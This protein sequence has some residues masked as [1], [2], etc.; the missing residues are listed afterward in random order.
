MPKIEYSAESSAPPERVLAAATDFTERR[1]EIWPNISRKFY[2]VHERGDD[3]ADV[4]EGSDSMGGVW[5]RERY[6]WSEPN[7]VRA[8]VSESNIFRDGMWELR[9]EPNGSGGS[10]VHV[11]NDRRPKGKGLLVA[12]FMLLGG[13]KFLT[14]HL[15]RTLGIIEAQE[16]S[17]A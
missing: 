1:P 15:R 8:T 7:T 16:A 9:V 3:W 11:V 2:V 5:A 13:K 14:Q 17:P 10:R 4:T 6:E 12:P